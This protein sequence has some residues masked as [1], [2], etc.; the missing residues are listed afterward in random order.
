KKM[1]Y[2]DP[3]RVKMQLLKRRPGSLASIQ[4]A[5]APLSS[6]VAISELLRVPL[7]TSQMFLSVLGDL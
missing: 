6:P 2:V 4:L 5:H 1:H 7:A 3:D